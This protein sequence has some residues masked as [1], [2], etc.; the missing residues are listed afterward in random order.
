VTSLDKIRQAI[1]E[2]VAQVMQSHAD[3]L[4]DQVSDRIRTHID[5]DA[6]H[7]ETIEQQ[8]QERSEQAQSLEQQLAQTREEISGKQ[9]H[10]E[11]V[12]QKLRDLESGSVQ[13]REEDRKAE[14]TLRGRI[15]E[16]EN[17][18]KSETERLTK[19]AEE[20]E[21]LLEMSQD[22]VKQLQGREEEQKKRL[23]E[24]EAQVEQ[25]RGQM[26]EALNQ[27]DQDYAAKTRELEEKIETLRRE[28]TESLQGKERE[29]LEQVHL[30]EELLV[31]GQTAREQQLDA[32]DREYQDAIAIQKTE[33]EGRI[34]EL[35]LQL[36]DRDKLAQAQGGELQQRIISLEA[37]L[38]SAQNQLADVRKEVQDTQAAF[39]KAQQQVDELNAAATARQQ[40]L[41]AGAQAALATEKAEFEG[42][43]SEWQQR[44]KDLNSQIAGL[45]KRVTEFAAAEQT[46]HGREQ[47]LLG[48]RDKVLSSSAE[49]SETSQKALQA[50]L[51]DQ[52][53]L[54][55]QLDAM[56]DELGRVREELQHAQQ[57]HARGEEQL[58]AAPA[59]MRSSALAAQPPQVAAA[60]TDGSEIEKIVQRL[61]G[62]NSQSDL[63]KTLLETTSQLAT[64]AG[65]LVLHGRSATGWGARGFKSEA[66]FRRATIDCS[67]GMAARVVQGRKYLYGFANEF[68]QKFMHSVGT[69][70]DGQAHLFPLVVQDRVVAFFYADGG[71]SD[72]G[73]IAAAAIEEVM[74]ASGAWL[75]ELATK[76]KGTPGEAAGDE[77]KSFAAMAAAVTRASNAPPEAPAPAPQSP[78]VARQRAR[79]FAKL[80]VDEIKLYNKDAV[81]VGR[82][83]SDLYDRLREP[84]D[85]SRASYDK[86]WGKTITDV[87]YFREELVRNLADNN[88]AVLGSNFPR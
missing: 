82:R 7:L 18:L 1:D 47:E 14:E 19:Q 32:K 41:A 81:E 17:T 51:E 66:D 8:L 36:A 50:A 44:E 87:D 21:Q 11:T 58:A 63:L 72:G 73:E 56:I 40:E 62:A 28:A 74:Q 34:T 55:T 30:L 83:N 45:E 12:E 77:G 22:E 35:Q 48:H 16:L 10:I 67:S 79:R 3:Q 43:R 38:A 57:A 4:R 39:E 75:D 70:V 33:H 5:E 78:D 86:R 23:Q 61:R 71:L 37:E 84:I 69:P 24:L 31:Q 49:A 53:R 25:L 88:V 68:D 80:L 29:L 52:A 20:L 64:R 54:Q 60:E 6:K 2:V 27:K 59:P 65:I 85:K 26:Q 15:G 46:W 42:Q 9:H 13:A 76:K